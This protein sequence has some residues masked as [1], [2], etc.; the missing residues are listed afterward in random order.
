L[1]LTPELKLNNEEPPF[2]IF[3]TADDPHGNSS[4]VMAK[5]LRDAK[6]SV[7]LHLLSFGGHGYGVRIGTNA[8][9]TWPLLAEKWLAEIAPV[10]K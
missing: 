4:L 1:S 7:E 10:N 3:Q 8:A 6:Q 2:F 9:K 5:A